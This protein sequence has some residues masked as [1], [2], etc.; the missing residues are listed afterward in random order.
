MFRLKRGDVVCDL[1]R[2]PES[3]TYMG[4]IEEVLPNGHVRV[5]WEDGTVSDRPLRKL[6]KVTAHGWTFAIPPSV[7]NDMKDKVLQMTDEE[8]DAELARLGR[9]HNLH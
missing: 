3:G 4:K 2:E 9:E 5:T 1:D 6:G 8:I 7:R